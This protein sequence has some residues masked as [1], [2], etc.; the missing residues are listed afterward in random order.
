M[1]E[2]E[3]RLFNFVLVFIHSFFFFLSFQF[4]TGGGG[5]RGGYDERRGGSDNYS[6]QAAMSMNMMNPAMINAAGM[7]G[8]SMNAM[9]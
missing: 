4:V 9:G 1:V 8:N 2:A 7:Y 5:G 6:R 3:V